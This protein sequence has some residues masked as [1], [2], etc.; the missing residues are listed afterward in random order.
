[1]SVYFSSVYFVHLPYYPLL[2]IGKLFS[3]FYCYKNCFRCAVSAMIEYFISA[4]LC[5]S[6]MFIIIIPLIYLQH[7][8]RTLSQHSIRS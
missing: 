7:T 5:S 8:F 6:L 2:I 4:R 3:E 1:M